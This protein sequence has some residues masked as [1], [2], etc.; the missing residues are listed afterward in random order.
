M[1]AR[2]H[3]G[4]LVRKAAAVAP[5]L[6]GLALLS[7]CDADNYPTDLQY[8]IRTD[9][10]VAE[11]LTSPPNLRMDKPGELLTLVYQVPESEKNKILDPA[12]L[13][14]GQRRDLDKLLDELFG[15]PHE[16][17]LKGIDDEAQEAVNA[18]GLTNASLTEGSHVYRRY[19]LHCH[20]L[21]GN[22]RGPTAPWV[23]PHPR[24]YRQGVFKFTS[25]SQPD[26][27]RKPRREDLLRT[28]REGIEGTSMPSFGLLPENEL[29]AVI[30]YVMHLSIR[31][32]LEYNLIK[33]LLKQDVD[34]GGLRDRA[35]DWQVAIAGYWKDAESKLIVPETPF[36]VS[37]VDRDTSV[38]NGYK[39]FYEDRA[40]T[41]CWKCHVD[42]GRQVPFFYDVWGTI[43]RPANFTEGVYRGGRRP[44]DLYWR[45]HSGI[46][47]AS[48]P[49]SSNS[50]N[51]KEIWDLVNFLEVLPYPK[52]REKYGIE[53]H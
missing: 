43:V 23:N 48:M 52:M 20:G 12:K 15:T 9:P 30:A 42:F 7:G 51:S 8:D 40:R 26:K 25:S 11:E 2:L 44:I 22:G 24:D 33:D 45:I 32:Q 29:N 13:P 1:T 19:C 46:N 47:G 10:L 38:A 39:L 14:A 41:G 3:V 28:L 37:A 31:G 49:G 35:K 17:K 50:L 53:I 21:T 5:V 34:E 4:S 36:P 27:V 16:P 18:L 6:I